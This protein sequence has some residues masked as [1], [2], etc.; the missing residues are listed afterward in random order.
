M[1]SKNLLKPIAQFLKVYADSTE[2]T[3]F[4]NPENKSIQ[5]KFEVDPKEKWLAIP[6]NVDEVPDSAKGF[7][8]PKGDP[9]FLSND[10]TPCFRYPLGALVVKSDKGECLVIKEG[11]S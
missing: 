8:S 6:D 3:A 5:V 2:G 9:N 4:E 10:D 7:I 1:P 11:L